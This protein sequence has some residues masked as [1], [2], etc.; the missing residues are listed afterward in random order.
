MKAFNKILIVEDDDIL[1]FILQKS[2]EKM[3]FIGIHRA[4]NYQDA[5]ELFSVINPEILFMDIHLLDEKTGIDF[6]KDIRT[7]SS[8]PAIFLSSTSNE[9]EIEEAKAIPNCNFMAKPYD[10]NTLKS[11]VF[12]VMLKN[13]MIQKDQNSMKRRVIDLNSYNPLHTPSISIA[14]C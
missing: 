2:L 11:M 4:S 3:G 6:V 13:F 7:F 10:F 12:S 8:V 1:A 14:K 5:L 9:E